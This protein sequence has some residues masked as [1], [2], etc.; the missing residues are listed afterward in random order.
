MTF[1]KKHIRVW[2]NQGGQAK[3]DWVG[4]L[5]SFGRFP[6]QNVHTA[7]FLPPKGAEMATGMASGEIVI[8]QVIFLHKQIFKQSTG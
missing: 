1:G 4:S 8:W 3:Q 7:L 6:M 2:A 5:L